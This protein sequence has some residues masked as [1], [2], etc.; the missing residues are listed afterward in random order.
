MFNFVPGRQSCRRSRQKPLKKNIVDFFT[1]IKKYYVPNYLQYVANGLRQVAQG[2]ERCD[3][4]QGADD[5]PLPGH[6]GEGLPAGVP[7]AA[8]AADG[9][10]G[11][12]REEGG[13]SGNEI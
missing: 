11:P 9:R 12:V 2:E 1:F 6:D 3:E 10:G 8:E 5:V 13:G 4:P 7:V